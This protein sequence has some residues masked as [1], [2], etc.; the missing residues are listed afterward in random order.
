MLNYEIVRYERDSN[1]PEVVILENA[2]ANVTNMGTL[3]V[4]TPD[5]NYIFPPDTWDTCLTIDA[6]IPSDIN[7]L[8]EVIV[9]SIWPY[10]LTSMHIYPNGMIHMSVEKRNVFKDESIQIDTYAQYI[11]SPRGYEF[12]LSNYLG[13]KETLVEDTTEIN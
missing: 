11:Y 8:Y 5:G 13:E 7:P 4:Q 2:K 9:D 6:D 3:I 12:M 10:L 1:E